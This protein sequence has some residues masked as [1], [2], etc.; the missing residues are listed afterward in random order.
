MSGKSPHN[1]VRDGVDVGA[2]YAMPW[3]GK[4]CLHS[5]DADLVDL[6]IEKGLVAPRRPPFLDAAE[7]GVHGAYHPRPQINLFFDTSIARVV[8][9]IRPALEEAG[10]EI[11]AEAA[12]SSPDAPAIS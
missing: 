8:E 11:A 7:D 1:I 10:Y 5:R 4:T 2:L 6:L 3:H 9:T 12:S